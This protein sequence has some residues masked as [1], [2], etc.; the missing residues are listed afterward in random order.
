MPTNDDTEQ[1]HHFGILV[2]KPNLNIFEPNESRNYY[3]TKV[4]GPEGELDLLLTE[5]D[6]KR[7]T[8]RAKKNSNDAKY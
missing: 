4:S 8:I 2:F 3:Y 5:S 1:Q 6:I 7:A